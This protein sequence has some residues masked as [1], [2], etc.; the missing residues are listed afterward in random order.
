MC[1]SPGCVLHVAPVQMTGGWA[2]G[3]VVWSAVRSGC[4]CSPEYPAR[5]PTSYTRKQVKCHNVLEKTQIVPPKIAW[6][7]KYIFLIQ[8]D[9]SQSD[10]MKR[11]DTNKQFPRGKRLY[12]HKNS[13]LAHFCRLLRYQLTEQLKCYI[14]LTTHT[15][16]CVCDQRANHLLHN[17]HTCTRHQCRSLNEC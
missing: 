4:P 6:I 14:H 11:T 16:A 1:F 13:E 12:L 5:M 2:G 8:T 3:R 15:T 10:L 9:L 17:K 7:K